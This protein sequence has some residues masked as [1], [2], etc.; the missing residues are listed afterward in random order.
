MRVFLQ[1]SEERF[2]DSGAGQNTDAE[3][4]RFGSGGSV[5]HRTAQL[6]TARH[7][8][9]SDMADYKQIDFW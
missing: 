2:I 5:S 1:I 8:I 9:G 4:E 6:K 7:N 3:A